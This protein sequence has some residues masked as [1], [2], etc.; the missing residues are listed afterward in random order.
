MVPVVMEKENDLC[1]KCK[2]SVNSDDKGLLCDGFC[3]AWF[4]AKCVE[5]ELKNYR[6]ITE[7]GDKVWWLC[8]EC[9]TRIDNMKS[10]VCDAN[11]YTKLHD[12]IGSLFKIVKDLSSD[13]LLINKKLDEVTL[14]SKT[15]EAYIYSLKPEVACEPLTLTSSASDTDFNFIE[16]GIQEV[17]DSD[18]RLEKSTNS[19]LLKIDSSTQMSGVR[20]HQ[21]DDANGCSTSDVLSRSS[22]SGP[23]AITASVITKTADD[24]VSNNRT[25]DFHSATGNVLSDDEEPNSNGHDWRVQQNNRKRKGNRRQEYKKTGPGPDPNG[26]NLK[27]SVSITEHRPNQLY[28]KVLSKQASPPKA[29]IIQPA[30]PSRGKPKSANRPTGLVGTQVDVS[31]S[32]EKRA[33]FH[34]GKIKSGTT[35]TDVMSFIGKSFP[36]IEFVVE[37]LETKGLNCSFKLGVDF[38]HKEKVLDSTKW[39]KYATLR[40]YFLYRRPLSKQAG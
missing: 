16:D 1:K 36:D 7:L 22:G 28:S 12:L 30:G 25:V 26:K 20:N 24:K 5:I 23:G 31:L 29:H 37:K 14:T 34:L 15:L 18:F 40:R 33:W 17:N 11:E 13:N 6:K 9:A 27:M 3:N 4:H 21:A 8:G 35:E 10:Y 32:G 19:S 2:I 38:E 39:P